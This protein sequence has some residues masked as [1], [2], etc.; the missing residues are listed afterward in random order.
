MPYK[1]QAPRSPDITSMERVAAIV[2]LFLL[3]L[4][5]P[6]IATAQI[7]IEP[8]R[9]VL[10]MD[11]RTQW[12]TIR[13]D[14]PLAQKVTP[15]WTDLIQAKDASLHPTGLE[16][17]LDEMPLVKLWPNNLVIK[18]GQT[19]RLS[20]LLNIDHAFA[21]EQRQHL[22]FN[23]DPVTGNGPRWA[24]II[25]VFIRS[26]LLSPSVEISN[27]QAHQDGNLYVTLRNTYGASPHGHLLV[28]DKNGHQMAEL[29]NV[30]LYTH[31]QKVTFAIKMPDW[32]KQSFMVRYLGN[33]EFTD[34]VFVEKQLM[35]SIDQPQ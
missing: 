31:N 20:V 15:V 24:V 14:G 34:T 35:I 33:A 12:I 19:I 25:P 3:F 32:P 10:S 18:A 29:N 9:I 1:S 21:G 30:N 5:V 16:K 27:V 23:L 26:E 13:N 8:T 17:P 11:N 28:I 4:A 6:S 2:M 22:R 7:N